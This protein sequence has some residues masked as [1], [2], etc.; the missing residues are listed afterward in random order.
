MTKKY[1]GHDGD[2]HYIIGITTDEFEFEER[3]F[4]RF[5]RSSYLSDIIKQMV[6]QLERCDSETTNNSDSDINIDSGF[7]INNI[8]SSFSD[9]DEDCVHPDKT[10]NITD[11]SYEHGK[12]F[13]RNN[14]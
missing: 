10:L 1:K 13:I 5:I 11:V 6:V 8:L 12:L 4:S 7:N 9:I 14:F 3:F 2:K